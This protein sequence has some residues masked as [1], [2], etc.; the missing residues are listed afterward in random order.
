MQVTT[1]KLSLEY[2]LLGSFTPFPEF[3]KI[4]KTRGPVLY[5]HSADR[6]CEQVCT[7]QIAISTT[8]CRLKF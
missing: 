1:W 3:R 7:Y 8:G 2:Q 4:R 5:V 6:V